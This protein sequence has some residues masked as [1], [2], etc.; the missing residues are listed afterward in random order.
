MPSTRTA[1]TKDQGWPVGV[2]YSRSGA[3]AVTESEHFFGTA[4]AIEEINALGGV[5][6]LP[7]IPTAYDPKGSPEEY[8]RLT[9]KLLIEDEINVIFGCSRSS[10]RKAVLSLVE[11]H[12][13]LLW[14]CSF[15][16]GFEYS[17]NIIYTG[18]VPNQNSIQLAAYL[19]QNKGTRF[20]LVGADYIYPRESNRIM[21]DVVEQYGGEIVDE[22]YLP[23][24]AGLEQLKDVLNEIRDAQPDVVFSTL[25][26]QS[27]RSFYQRYGE[28]GLDPKKIPIASLSMA[29]EEIRLIGPQLCEGH[30]TAATYFGS[31]PND[32]NQRF[33]EL[34]RQRFGDRPT[35]TWSEMAYSQVHLFARA[36]E[37]AGSLDRRKLVDAVHKVKFASPEGPIAIDAENNHCVLT[38]RIGICRSDGQF[39][40][41]WEGSGP[42]KPDP[43]LSTF[44]F[45]EFWLR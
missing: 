43:Y 39:D 42:V 30:I 38:P 12:N 5:L 33:I 14:Y 41:V 28:H 10:S 34:W 31:L 32:S 6:N 23:I 29:E 25:V 19:L 21:R 35:S 44:G 8:R 17:P 26:G 37:R 24:D 45:S 7:L 40:V 15:Y 4:L 16:E 18:A 3:T 2:L 27:A 9:G 13:A 11:R 20:F 1:V 36:L 22:V